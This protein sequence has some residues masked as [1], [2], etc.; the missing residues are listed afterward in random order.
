[1]KKISL[2]SN[3]VLAAII[4][5]ISCNK[6]DLSTSGG[7]NG[8]DA[9]TAAGMK[10]GQTSKVSCPACRDYSTVPLNGML[11][12]TAKVISENYKSENQ[13]LLQISPGNDDANSVWF[14]LETLKNFIYKIESAACQ[15]GC[16]DR[17]HLGLRLY[18]AKYPVSNAM[19]EYDDLQ[20]VDTDFGQHHTIFMIPTYQ[21]DVNS[22]DHIDFDPWHWGNNP[23]K[24]TSMSEWF[25]LLGDKP[26]GNDNSLIFSLNEDQYFTTS[27]GGITPSA[28]NHGDLIPPYPFTGTAY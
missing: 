1:M 2:L 17:L 26:F 25:S 28:L 19:G 16:S 3:M 21:T 10:T 15:K 8:T 23:C 7:T 24:P 11:A 5:F 6:T 12:S 9:N 27:Q 18:Y 14:S 13:P 22:P 20:G 4:L